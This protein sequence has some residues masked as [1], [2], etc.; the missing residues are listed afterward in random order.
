MSQLGP[1]PCEREAIRFGAELPAAPPGAGRWVLAATIL[2]S[3]LAF[4]DGTVVTVALPAIAREFHATGFDVQWVVEAYALFLSALLLVGGSLG[5]RF[6]RRRVFAGGIV[7]FVV[8]SIGC[9]FATSM[10]WLIAWRAL[11]GIGAALLVPGSLALLSACFDADQRGRAIGTWSGSSGITTAVGPVIGGWLIG[12]SW[13]WAFFLNVPLAAIVLLLLRRVPE[14]RNSQASRLDWPGASLATVGLGGLVYALIESSRRGWS[15]PTV[16]AGLV[17]GVVALGA[18]I[19]VESR[20]AS[21]M[22]PLALFRS[23]TFAG[24]NALTF[25]LYGALSCALFYLPLDL[26]QVQGYS[27]LQAGAALLPLIL[28]LF[29]LSRWSGGLVSRHG[30]RRPLLLGPAVAA[31]GF[32]L[33]AVPGIGGSYWRTFFP[34]MAVLGLGMALSIAPLTTSVMNAVGEEH[35]GVASGVNNAVSRAAGLV[36]I[37]MLGIVFTAVFGATLERQ[38]DVLHLDPEVRSAVMAARDRLTM[39]APPPSVR[40]TD[41]AAVKEAVG[42]SFVTAFRVIACSAAGLAVL[43]SLC[44]AIWIGRPPADRGRQPAGIALLVQ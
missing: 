24:V 33:L 6:G 32:G 25:F 38:V 44:A 1:L 2:G 27:P 12:H 36:A 37:A 15:D 20:V 18:F 17:A 16:V 9:G 19:A 35:A 23:R 8:A 21:P 26:I 30:A 34:G 29:V 14:R 41:V 10:S 7:V 4:I 40:G 5:D 13:R 28:V 31:L 22:L 39:A 3:S 43:A 11:Q 42:T